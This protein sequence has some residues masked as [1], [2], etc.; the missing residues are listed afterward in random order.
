M[1]KILP[2]ILTILISLNAQALFEVK[3][4]SDN[5]VFSISN[6]GMRVINAG[7]TMMVI[8]T[9]E[10][11]I[12]LDNSKG[13]SR[14]F[15]VSTNT[16]GKGVL[17]NVLEV[18][19]GSTKMREGDAGGRYTDFSPEN[20]FLG[21][22]A[23]EIKEPAGEGNGENNIF[24]GNAAGSHNSDGGYNIFIGNEAGSNSNSDFNMFIGFNSGNANIGGMSNTFVGNNTGQ[25]YTWGNRNSLFGTAA[26]SRNNGND[27]SIFGENAGCGDWGAIY[28]RNCLF[29]S[30]C[31]INLSTGSDNI[32]IGYRS[33][34]LNQTG[35]GNTF[36]G[37]NAG[38][39]ETGSNK[40]YID[41]SNTS[42]P[43]IYG[44]FDNDLLILN[45]SKTHLKHP[46]GNTTNGLFIQSTYN[47]NTDSW[48]FYQST[49]DH[50]NLFYNT[51]LRG[52]W[53]LNSG[54]Y[55]SSS[56]KKFKK[57]IKE[58]AKVMD[59]V[60]LLQPKK[61]NFISQKNN[62]DKYIGLIAQDVEKLFPEF[63]MY[64]EEANAYTMD[65][66]GLSVIAIQ[67]IKEQ[68]TEIEYLKSEIEKIK[69]LLN[70]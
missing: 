39:N 7:D 38:Y 42:T 65:Y 1:K 53:D 16:T 57:N 69:N 63:V 70:K 11:R 55:S 51:T 61:Y 5:T 46:L 17:A 35:D 34:Y 68:Q 37:S 23:G 6:D 27:N 13:L 52:T 28:S 21:L 8:S 19:T 56:D 36:I 30:S 67:A 60:M 31:G 66:A 32:M 49:G 40:L 44:E 50:L 10:A 64:N 29:G 47:S 2:V 43:L 20:I 54:V 3:D 24:I 45:T 62:E 41:N 33:G 4:A 59:R 18:T 12:S 22:N 26:S 9:S 15:S 25:S 14:S 48:H 58:L